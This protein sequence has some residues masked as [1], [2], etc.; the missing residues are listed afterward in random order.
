MASKKS[1]GMKRC[2]GYIKAYVAFCVMPGHYG[3]GKKKPTKKKGTK[4]GGKKMRCTCG[5]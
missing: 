2:E 3:G 5:K 1:N 4:K